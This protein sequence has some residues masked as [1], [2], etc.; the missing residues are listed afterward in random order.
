MHRD[1]ALTIYFL[2]GT[3]ISFGFPVQRANDAARGIMLDEILAKPYLMIEA[4]GALL[5]Y[6]MTSVK[7][8]Q[9][10]D[11]SGNTL[12]MPDKGIV[13]GATIIT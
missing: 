8:I 3:H 6:P 11:L 12:A 2:D 13:R 5:V 4:D 1:R 10:S 9:I 7:S